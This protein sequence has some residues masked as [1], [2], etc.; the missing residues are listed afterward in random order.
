MSKKGIQPHMLWSAK[1]QTAAAP[2]ALIKPCV[3]SSLLTGK[4]RGFF[5]AWVQAVYTALKETESRATDLLPLWKLGPLATA[6]VPR[7]VRSCH[8]STPVAAHSRDTQC[9]QLALHMKQILTVKECV[10]VV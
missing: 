7:Q 2:V 8:P 6:L 5:L 10:A 3:F 4:H 1:N 9:N